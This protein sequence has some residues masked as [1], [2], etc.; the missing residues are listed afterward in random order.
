MRKT[1]I[2]MAVAA[3]LAAGCTGM[4]L[5]YRDMSAEQIRATAGTITCSQ[6][7][8]IYGSGSVIALNQDDTRK[9]ATSKGKTTIKCGGAEMT[10]DAEVG[11]PVPAG[12]TTTTTT[13]VRPTPP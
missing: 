12:A 5:G 4:N 2:A 6:A 8:N 1:T 10:I 7:T 3:L 9:G 13:V 11:V